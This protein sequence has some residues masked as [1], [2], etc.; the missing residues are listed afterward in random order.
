M[1]EK[2][3][4]K[5]QN[6]KKLVTTTL[7]IKSLLTEMHEEEHTYDFML[8]LGQ[9]VGHHAADVSPQRVAHTRDLLAAA[10][11]KGNERV[12]LRTEFEQLNPSAS[13]HAKQTL[14]PERCIETP[15]W[16]WRATT[17][18]TGKPIFAPSRRRTR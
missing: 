6:K 16:C 10:P 1:S 3:S 4:I 13:L 15:V 7:S 11:G 9:M 5:S 17:G 12:E 14:L 8:P 18:N 2:Q